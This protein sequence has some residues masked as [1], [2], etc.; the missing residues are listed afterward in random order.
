MGIRFAC[1]VCTHQLNIKSE[2]AGRRGVCPSCSSR[3]R[4]PLENAEKSTPIDEQT[5][6]DPVTVAATDPPATILDDD[7]ESNWY[8]RPPSG[9]QYGPATTELLKQ[10]IEEGRVAATALLWRDG[11]PQWRDA[12]EALPELI[13]K[14]PENEVS[15][16]NEMSR[17][18]EV[19]SK[20]ASTAE[21]S[22]R[23][24]AVA[25]TELSQDDSTQLTGKADVGRKRRKRSHRRV[26]L[27]G[28]L[29]ALAAALIVVLFFV[30]NR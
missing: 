12:S 22:S 11:W 27:I 5:N 3:F 9:G 26:Y 16:R 28:A 14:L 1:H 13:A 21:L 24:P 2:L 8:V 7:D 18:N 25:S 19:S 10:W 6:S 15:D 23:Q 29:T 20:A 4:I 17:Q 30:A